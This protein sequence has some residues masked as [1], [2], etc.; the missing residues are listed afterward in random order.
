MFIA[1]LFAGRIIENSPAERCH[2]L[3]VGDRILAVNGQ[4]ILHL[5]HGDIVSMIKDSGY[6]VSLRIG[7]PHGNEKSIVICLWI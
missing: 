2:K 1:D 3:R 4:S 5:P 6:S 7:P